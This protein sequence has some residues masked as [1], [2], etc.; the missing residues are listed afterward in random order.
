MSA[1]HTDRDVQPTPPEQTAPGSN[2]DARVSSS[3]GALERAR[4]AQRAKAEGRLDGLVRQSQRSEQPQLPSTSQAAEAVPP[5]GKVHGADD[6]VVPGQGSASAA[7]GFARLVRHRGLGDGEDVVGGSQ[8]SPGP[9]SEAAGGQGATPATTQDPPPPGSAGSGGRSVYSD[10]ARRS[11]QRRADLDAQEQR[12]AASR[13][14]PA[15]HVRADRPRDPPWPEADLPAGS[16]YSAQE[17]QAARGLGNVW[18]FEVRNAGQGC[19]MAVDKPPAPR[20]SRR[21]ENGR[22]VS[23][24][25][26]VPDSVRDATLPEAIG[27]LWDGCLLLA[28]TARTSHPGA[29]T[30][31][32]SVISS[33]EVFGEQVYR[34][35]RP[36]A[37]RQTKPPYYFTVKGSVDLRPQEDAKAE[38]RDSDALTD[39]S[40]ETVARPRP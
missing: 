16:A 6:A 11:A 1:S 30:G 33:H 34:V 18:V 39:E 9:L 4:A 14:E 20:I 32:I 7:A 29:I 31:R 28:P 36:E 21:L 27:D 8:Q 24:V 37:H 35:V 3:L 2:T 12:L 13:Q 25:E 10:L 40:M 23:V 19:L 38:G 15:G 22:M 5:S 26:P 17:W